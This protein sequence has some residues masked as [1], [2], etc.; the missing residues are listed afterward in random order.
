MKAFAPFLLLASLVL[1]AAAEDCIPPGGSEA[2]SFDRPSLLSPG[3]PTSAG[4]APNE[5]SPKAYDQDLLRNDP[6]GAG[7]PSRGVNP[8]S[9][10]SVTITN[11]GGSLAGPNGVVQ[12]GFW[13]GDCLEV[14]MCW[15][16]RYKAKVKRCTSHGTQSQLRVGET[17][18][19]GSMGSS[20][21]SSYCVEYEVWLKGV[22]CSSSSW[23]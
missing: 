12:N 19:G 17:G 1:P 2:V 18:V 6:L 21:G 13:E 20:S 11:Q 4:W 5:G 23:P 10:A 15:E 7:V 14:F 8:G 16:Y 22:V 3:I 9:S